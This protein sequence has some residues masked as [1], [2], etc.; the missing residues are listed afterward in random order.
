MKP[1]VTATEARRVDG[2]HQGGLYEAMERAGLAVALAAVRN[3]AGYGKRVAV[4]C[5][6]GNNGGDGYVAARHLKARGAFPVVY[7][8]APPRTPDAVRAAG[9]AAA[10]GVPF[11]PL[12]DPEPAD[13]VIDAVFGGGGRGDLPGPVAAWAGHEAPLIAVDFPTGLDPDSG[14]A[15]PVCFRATETVTFS[16]YKTGHLLDDGP[17]HC[18]TVTVADIGLE[19]GAPSAWVAGEEDAPR[20]P[21]LRTAHKWSAG[22]VLVVGGS[23]GMTGAATMAAR[24]ALEFGAGA[25]YLATPEAGV[26]HSVVPQIPAFPLDAVP[27]PERFDVVVAGPGLA[28]AD[29]DAALPLVEGAKRVVLDAGALVPAVVEAATNAGAEVVVTPHAAEFERIAGVGVGTF[30]I[31]SYALRTGVVVLAKGN[32][33]RVTDGGLPVFVRSGTQALASIGTGDVL[34][35]MLGALWA[36]GL[37]AMEAA[38]SAAYWHG[39][40]AAGLSRVGTVTAERLLGE[41]GRW[42]W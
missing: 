34:A 25:V 11:R 8:L 41:I 38:V 30:S 7:R 29:L 18:G 2:S 27:R 5:G 32:P 22:A 9:K 24:A 12:G 16:A 20:P 39:R 3:G 14:R 28:A 23:A 33:T 1:V 42:A 21:R 36:R 17:D 4:L 40:V 35:G 15:G 37:G 26:A 19:T 10:A 6:P 31:R 13:L